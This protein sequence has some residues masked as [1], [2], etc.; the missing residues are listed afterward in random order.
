MEPNSDCC[1][2]Y[3]KEY[4]YDAELPVWLKIHTILLE[5][6]GQLPGMQQLQFNIT[7]KYFTLK[8]NDS[9]EVAWVLISLKDLI[10]L[11][12]NLKIFLKAFER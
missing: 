5:D 12:L 3:R 9:T 8:F 11:K 7:T 4:N 2:P 1:L 6:F 10:T